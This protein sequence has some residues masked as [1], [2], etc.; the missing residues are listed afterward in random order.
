MKNILHLPD[1]VIFKAWDKLQAFS[2]VEMLMALLVAS[3]LLAA[4]APVMTK[5][6]HTENLHI[7][8][9]NNNLQEVEQMVKCLRTSDEIKLEDIAFSDNRV[10]FLL[11]SGGGGGGGASGAYKSSIITLSSPASSTT[12][13]SSKVLNLNKDMTDFE[14][15]TLIGGG[16]GGGGG[17]FTTTGN[18]DYCKN[19]GNGKTDTTGHTGTLS[20]PIFVYASGNKKCVTAYGQKAAGGCTVYSADGYSIPICTYSAAAAACNLLTTNVNSGVF[21]MPIV[22][23]FSSWSTA[24]ATTAPPNGIDEQSCGKNL[25]SPCQSFGATGKFD[26]SNKSIY[27]VGAVWSSST[28]NADWAQTNCA[29]GVSVL[30][31]HYFARNGSVTFEGGANCSAAR[32][33]GYTDYSVVRCVAVPFI[34]FSGGGGGGA[35][36]I[37][38]KDTFNN[39]V[40]TIFKKAIEDNLENGSILIEAGKGGDK[41]AKGTNGTNASAGGNGGESCVSIYSGKNSTGSLVFKVCAAGGNGGKGAISSLSYKSGA[42]YYAAGG[43]VKPANSCY[44]IN[45]SGS[46]ISFN[47]AQEGSL[48]EHGYGAETKMETTWGHG[49]A[50]PLSLSTFAGT[51]TINGITLNSITYAGSGGSGGRANT[52]NGTNTAGDG[53]AGASGLAKITYKIKKDGAGGGGGAGGNAVK[54]GNIIF[55]K[56]YYDCKITVG[57]G[58]IGGNAGSTQSSGAAANGGDGTSGGNSSITC[59]GGNTTFTVTGANG[60]KGGIGATASTDSAGG[61]GGAALSA[62]NATSGKLEG[63]KPA[64]VYLVTGKQG[65]TPDIASRETVKIGGAG[66]KSGTKALGGCGGTEV[67]NDAENGC[68]TLSQTSPDGKGFKNDD[69][70]DAYQFYGSNITTA[71]Q[72][73]VHNSAPSFGTA[74]AGGGGGSYQTIDSTGKGGNGMAG[75]ACVFYTR[76]KK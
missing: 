30:V 16:G 75:Y 20:N 10:T 64:M 40:K 73:I 14:L 59:D 18:A 45:S 41:G 56:S 32:K 34:S 12:A 2:L 57:Q 72:N 26:E 62:N 28:D 67:N 25:T 5:K 39:E 74:G 8:S 47:C 1:R 48:G 43:A 17:T 42:S 22:S 46:K 24:F 21:T 63:L 50:S 4:L 27:R 49:G 61:A 70:S 52:N 31:Y 15:E 44:Y 53:G 7:T 9:T 29:N 11:V 36:G 76:A 60:G 58:G 68:I 13:Y 54:I 23:D 37:I 35:T 55:N 3:L 38:G 65:N 33:N 69:V 6:M 66:G 71:W 51:S 19:L